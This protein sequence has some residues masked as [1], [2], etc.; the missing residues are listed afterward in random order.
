MVRDSKIQEEFLPLCKWLLEAYDLV[1]F[2]KQV[3]NTSNKLHSLVREQTEIWL[4]I[5]DLTQNIED[6]QVKLSRLMGCIEEAESNI[7][8]L[9]NTDTNDEKEVQEV[10]DKCEKAN[11]L[12]RKSINIDQILSNFAEGLNTHWKEKEQ[13]SSILVESLFTSNGFEPELKEGPKE[14]PKQET[15]PRTDSPALSME[16]T[17]QSPRH[18]IRPSKPKKVSKRKCCGFV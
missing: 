10:K 11:C 5:K 7:E 6:T 4:E 9:K 15:N 13:G 8:D 1:C 17:M 3:V 18:Q 16:I 12:A 2:E 14:T